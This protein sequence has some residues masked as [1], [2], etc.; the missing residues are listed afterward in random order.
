MKKYIEGR[1]SQEKVKW[2]NSPNVYNKVEVEEVGTDKPKKITKVCIYKSL[3]NQF[4][5][6]D[7]IFFEAVVSNI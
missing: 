6:H 5:K 1:K 2:M 3:K 4:C 7:E